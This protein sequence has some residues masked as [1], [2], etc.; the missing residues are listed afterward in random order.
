MDE[1]QSVPNQPA[2]EARVYPANEHKLLIAVIGLLG[3]A[4]FVAITL[5]MKMGNESVPVPDLVLPAEEMVDSETVRVPANFP[6]EVA[7]E[8]GAVLEQGYTLASAEHEQNTV[9]FVSQ[10]TV[11]ENYEAY[12]AQ[13]EKD[14]WIIVNGNESETISSLYALRRNDEINVTIVPGER[15]GSEVSISVV[16]K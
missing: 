2:Q 7:I 8:D 1:S 14:F 3:V 13:L 9:V 5:N 15:S 4:L 6:A 11:K 16:T 10:K 12:K